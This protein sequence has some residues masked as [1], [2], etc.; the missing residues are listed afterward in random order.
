MFK[1]LFGSGIQ[2]L[3]GPPT[4]VSP[5]YGTP[6]PD[7]LEI[8]TLILKFVVLPVVIPVVLTV[9]VLV[10]MKRKDYPKAKRIWTVVIM[11]AIYFALFVGA[12]F[13]FGWF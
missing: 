2:D 10:Y 3:Y 4:E 13:L 7:F 8:L 1:W 11:L 12:G 6:R 9:G 5:L